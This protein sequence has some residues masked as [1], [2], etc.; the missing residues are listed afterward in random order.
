MLYCTHGTA[1]L[2]ARS[3]TLYLPTDQRQSNHVKYAE[4]VLS[5]TGQ[6]KTGT[7]VEWIVQVFWKICLGD[8]FQ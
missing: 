1:G 4:N 6:G 7:F 8:Y 3:L 2:H 5:Y